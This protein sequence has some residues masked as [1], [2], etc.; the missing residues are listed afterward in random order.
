MKDGFY[1]FDFELK[2]AELGVYCNDYQLNRE[3]KDIYKYPV[4]GWYWF[5]SDEDAR[6]FFNF[7]EIE[8]STPEMEEI[9]RQIEILQAVGRLEL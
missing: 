2:Y 1:K 7:P 3:A 9:D 6:K 4:D 5:D 8:E